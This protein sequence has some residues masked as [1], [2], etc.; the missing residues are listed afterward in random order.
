MASNHERPEDMTFQI[1]AIPLSLT[2]RLED[3]GNNQQLAKMI[4]S[5]DTEDHIADLSLIHI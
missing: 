5:I 3:W 1:R 2:E 4:N